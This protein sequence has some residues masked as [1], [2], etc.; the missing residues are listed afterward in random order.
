MSL[1]AGHFLNIKPT[2]FYVGGHTP[3][4]MHLFTQIFIQQKMPTYFCVCKCIILVM[5]CVKIIVIEALFS[6]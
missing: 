4:E 1:I 6:R 3:L 2:A 5:G